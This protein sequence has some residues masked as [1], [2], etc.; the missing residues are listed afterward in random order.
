VVSLANVR[1]S[2]FGEAYGAVENPSCIAVTTMPPLKGSVLLVLDA[3]IAFSLFTRLLGGPLEEPAQVRDFTELESGMARRLVERLLENLRGAAE[4]LVPLTPAVAQIENNPSYVQAFS[5]T[6]MVLTLQFS[7]GLDSLRGTLSLLMPLAAFEPV[8][9]LF[10]PKESME[11]RGPAEKGRD[12]KLAAGL[13]HGA[14]AQVSAR[15]RSRRASLRELLE[16]REGDIL[17]L[18]HPVNAPLSL[19]VEGKH[20]FDG[21]PGRVGRSRAVR[22]VRR[23]KES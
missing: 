13:L 16:L 3:S 2:S 22:I 9:S 17:A 19:S 5:D 7:V 12:R 18:A 23:A 6:E 11:L 4:R 20:M 14:R 21:V 15:F 10:D 1:V 8:R